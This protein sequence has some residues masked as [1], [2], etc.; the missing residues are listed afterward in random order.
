MQQEGRPRRHVQLEAELLDG[1]A[2]ERAAGGGEERRRRRR[3]RK[4]AATQPSSAGASG[5]LATTA[6]AAAAELATGPSEA[7]YAAGVV[8]GS[9]PSGWLRRSYA[10]ADAARAREGQPPAPAQQRL[11]QPPADRRRAARAARPVHPAP[12]DGHVPI[13]GFTPARKRTDEEK[14]AAAAA[15]TAAAAAATAPQR[16]AL[17]HPCP[18]E[19]S[20]LVAPAEP[21]SGRGGAGFSV[22]SMG[23]GAAHANAEVAKAQGGGS[24]VCVVS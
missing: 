23:S 15:A 7:A 3:R 2:A 22:S 5:A 6:S 16:R 11:A 21:T 10:M 12:D 13:N 8:A 14:A 19:P 4:G 20:P 24:D 17:M 1:P 9:A 18:S